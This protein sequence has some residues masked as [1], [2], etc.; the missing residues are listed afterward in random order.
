MLYSIQGSVA[1]N[2]LFFLAPISVDGY[3]LG[4]GPLIYQLINIPIKYTFLGNE[5]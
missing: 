4:P 2:G 3:V 1:V 5:R